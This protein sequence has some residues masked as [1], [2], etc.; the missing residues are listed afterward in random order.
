MTVLD[1]NVWIGYLYRGDPLHARAR[2]V[3]A[4]LA[5]NAEEVLLPTYVILEV[6]TVLRVRAGAQHA[7]Q[8]IR[9]ATTTREIKI[10]SLDSALFPEVARLVAAGKHPGLSFTDLALLLLARN[11]SVVTF[12]KRLSAAIRARRP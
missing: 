9:Y 3:V 11:H 2:T 10:A 8:F 6:V 5:D 1:S 4:N 12:D 7:A